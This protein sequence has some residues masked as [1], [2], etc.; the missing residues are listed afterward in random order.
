MVIISEIKEPFSYL[1]VDD[2]LVG[3]ISSG[4]QLNNCLLQIKR[5]KL[6]G[7]YLEYDNIK[8]EIKNNGRIVDGSLIYPLLSNQ[9]KEIMGF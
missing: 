9:M 7:Y 1:Y 4:L 5:Q 6:D 3:R 2:V 8:Y